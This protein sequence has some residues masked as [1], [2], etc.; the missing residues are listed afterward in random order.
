[1]SPENSSGVRP[2]ASGALPFK[3][4]FGRLV[5]QTRDDLGLTQPDAALK[6]YGDEGRYRQIS[7]IERGRNEPSSDTI[8]RYCAGLGIDPDVVV[9][10]RNTVTS[11]WPEV[12]DPRFFLERPIIGR[13]ND[14][15]FLSENL[16]ATD[17]CVAVKGTGG[18]G[19]TTVARKYVEDFGHRYYGV[20]WVRSETPGEIF[21]DLSGLAN[22]FGISASDF[23]NEETCARAVVAAL[24]SDD[25]PWLLVY[26][27]AFEAADLFGWIPDNQACLVTSREGNWPRQFIVQEVGRL[28]PEHA[29]VLLSQESG[30]KSDRSGA[31]RLISALDF[32]PLAIV[33]AG[34]WLKDTTESY[35]EYIEQLEERIEETPRD[36]GVLDYEHT[37]HATI[38]LSLDRLSPNASHLMALFAYLAPED[39]WPGLLLK[40]GPEKAGGLEWTPTLDAVPDALKTIA[41]EQNLV[42]RS[43]AEL[44]R[45]SLLAEAA[46]GTDFWRTGFRLHRLTS[47]VQRGLNA[48]G[49]ADLR[50]AV[51]MIAMNYP[52]EPERIE[53]WPLCSRL[54]PHVAALLSAELRDLADC[55]VVTERLI[56]LASIWLDVQRVDGTVFSYSK[57]W[58]EI[59]RQNYDANHPNFAQAANDVAVGYWRNGQLVE[60]EEFASMAANAAEAGVGSPSKRAVWLGVYGMIA[61][62]RGSALS[63]EP[64]KEILSLAAR[65]AQAAAKLCRQEFGLYSREFATQIVRLAVLR[66]NQ[67]RWSMAIRLMARAL[68]AS[69]NA[70]QPNDP[71]LANSLCHLA[72]T[73]LQ[74]G[75]GRSGY[76]GHRTIDLLTEALAICEE[77]F[78]DNPKHPERIENAKWL[79]IAVLALAETGD[80][81]AD[82]GLANQVAKRYDLKMEEIQELAK[83]FKSRF[84]AFL[85]DGTEPKR[86]L[87]VS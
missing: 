85:F 41:S 23:P 72:K 58:F 37:L 1:M 68:S 84:T 35:D 12:R 6:V 56:E 10:L 26:D 34:G 22:H 45:R 25:R 60:A 16:G 38:S 69:R 9:E 13:E 81:A 36:L 20:W 11:D 76:R 87:D 52:V 24:A 51:A 73:L 53:N 42:E 21:S 3:K 75:R 31:E 70:L 49:V 2:E 83:E 17:H 4:L 43:F 74:S 15:E 67:G 82:I 59:A 46:E 8:S 77:S 64:K 29:A 50:S 54:Q 39:I 28:T 48:D 14:V 7:D 30:R 78:S 65:R 55:G 40:L 62:A 19:K 18:I 47:F 44:K 32:L 27:N 61:D 71:E 33:L 57:L 5:K 66:S 63:G 79:V 80:P 86:P